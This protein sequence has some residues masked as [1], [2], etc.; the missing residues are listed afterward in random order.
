MQQE[1]S[2]SRPYVCLDFQ[3]K[4]PFKNPAKSSER[5]GPGYLEAARGIP[6]TCS[7]ANVG[8]RQLKRG[9][10]KYKKWRTYMSF[11]STQWCNKEPKS[12]ES[13]NSWIKS[14]YIVK[15]R[16]KNYKGKWLRKPSAQQKWIL[17]TW[18]KWQQRKTTKSWVWKVKSLEGWRLA[19]QGHPGIEGQQVAF[20]KIDL[21][22]ENYEKQRKN[23]LSE[24]AS[25]IEALVPR[26][27]KGGNQWYPEP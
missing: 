21:K 4:R 2:T 14:Q 10:T 3:Q 5:T 12:L 18:K 11:S 6:G 25:I 15:P 26:E 22:E 7:T 17:L 20:R 23:Q 27:P 9:T 19:L 1:E 24:M 16:M 8:L 13:D